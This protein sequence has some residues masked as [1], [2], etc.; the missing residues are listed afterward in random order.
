MDKIVKIAKALSDPHRVRALAALREGEL[1]LCHLIELFGQVPSTVSKHMSVLRD[2]GLVS[3]ER[4]GKWTFYSLPH[5]NGSQII[6]HSLQLVF[7]SINKSS[8][9]H[10]D[11]KRIETIKCG[12]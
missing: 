11:R 9:I 7:E 3:S 8:V 1:C 5:R 12:E 10:K 4:R 2:A 6:S